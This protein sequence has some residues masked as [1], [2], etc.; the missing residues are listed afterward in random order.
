MTAAHGASGATTFGTEFGPDMSI[1][2]IGS[3]MTCDV[4]GMNWKEIPRKETIGWMVFGKILLKET[5]AWMVFGKI[6][7]EETIGWMVFGKI[8]ESKP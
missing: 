3:S 4:L 1:W 5:I 8:P 2:V 7:L 6:P